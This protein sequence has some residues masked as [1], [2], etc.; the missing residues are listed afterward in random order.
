MRYK[1]L[2]EHRLTVAEWA[3]CQTENVLNNIAYPILQPIATDI[4]TCFIVG[5]GHSGTTLVAEKMGRNEHC[6]LVNR[7]TGIFIPPAGLRQAKAAVKEWLFFTECNHKSLLIEKT[8]KHIHTLH[9]IR[10]IL[11]KSYIIAM[12]RNPLDNVASLY[13]RFGDLDFSTERWLIDNRA[14]V[15]NKNKMSDFMTMKYEELTAAPEARFQEIFSFIETAWDPEVLKEGRSSFN[16]LRTLD[17]IEHTELRVKQVSAAIRSNNGNWSKVLSDDQ[18]KTVFQRTAGL[19]Q[20][21]G[22]DFEFYDS[23]GFASERFKSIV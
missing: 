2:L 5:C 13:R 9:R 15:E 10:K 16:M 3:K 19:A 23:I 14:I 7:E 21:L 11:P 20:E 22:Y 8:P 4:K 1:Y 6:F 12:T 17:D 18:A